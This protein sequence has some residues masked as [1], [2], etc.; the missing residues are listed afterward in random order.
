MAN[1]AT[2]AALSGPPYP[3]AV[4]PP[5]FPSRPD[6]FDEVEWG[7]LPSAK[8]ARLA[9]KLWSLQ[10]G[11]LANDI[12]TESEDH[13]Y[14]I[15]DTPS[16]I[17]H[18]SYSCLA[19]NVYEHLMQKPGLSLADDEWNED[20]QMRLAKDGANHILE[21]WSYKDIFGVDPEVELDPQK[22]ILG[23]HKVMSRHW[24]ISRTTDELRK[25]NV[26]V[27]K[28]AKVAG[29]RDLL[30]KDE[31]EK[32][33]KKAEDMVLGLLPREDQ[34]KWGIPRKNDFM[35]DISGRTSFRPLDMYTWAI[36]LS[37]YNPTYWV[38]R[39]Y[40]YYQMGYFDLA[41]GDVHRAQ[42][43][44]ETITNNKD[45]NKQPGLNIRIWNAVEQHLLEIPA[46]DENLSPE[47]ELMR[48]S[49]GI[50]YFIPTVRKALHHIMSL[51]LLALQCWKD[52]DAMD[53]YLPSRMQ[54]SA[55]DKDA[56]TD[57]SRSLE[58]FVSHSRSSRRNHH[59][60]AY[61][62]YEK[63]AGAAPGRT[64]PY[65]A[66]DV[67]RTKGIFL[68]KIDEDI[69]Q[70]SQEESSKL[71]IDKVG[72]TPVLSVFAKEKIKAGEV[73]YVDEPSARGHLLLNHTRGNP[74]TRCEN[75][76]AVI[77]NHDRKF[78][79]M[80]SEQNPRAIRNHEKRFLC[81]CVFAKDSHDEVYFCVPQYQEKLDIQGR[82]A[83]GPE[84]VSEETR[85]KRVKRRKISK[86]VEATQ[87][88][89][90]PSC[91]EIAREL[92]H[93]RTCG[94]DWTWLHDAMRPNWDRRL[95]SHRDTHDVPRSKY[96]RYSHANE[97]HCTVLSLLLREIFDITL[98]RREKEDKPNLLAHEIEEMMPLM[99]PEDLS[100]QQ[101][102]FTLAANIKVP[103]DILLCLGVDIF[104]DLTFDTW[105][106]QTVL[107]KLL[108]NAVPWDGHRRGINDYVDHNSME[109]NAPV[110]Y[111]WEKKDYKPEKFDP[112]I[113][114][115]YLF[116]GLSMFNHAC[117][118]HH[119]TTWEWDKKI[120]NRVMVRATQS[121]EKNEE[122]VL[123]Y[124]NRQF[125]KDS[126]NR[127]LG[128]PCLC[129]L[130]NPKK[131]EEG[132]PPRQSSRSLKNS[133]TFVESE[134]SESEQETP[135]PDESE[136][137]YSS[138]PT[139]PPDVA[140]PPS[141]PRRGARIKIA[142]GKGQWKYTRKA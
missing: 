21:G 129:T 38:S 59:A 137:S 2:A 3:G 97:T 36:L 68:E 101:F 51:S 48:Q 32:R 18:K 105:V 37:P 133:P 100:E 47:A 76:K 34:S 99:G 7:P 131:P 15:A 104:R 8:D 96:E 84:T 12:N 14:P 132:L 27:P 61:F 40:L 72:P 116:P 118:N 108:I 5:D 112:T 91:V 49:N 130:C 85:N 78:Y 89:E 41:L 127:V 128:G 11:V 102:P 87:R 64:Y 66:R 69:L 71:E 17:A 45:K 54:M 31:I 33:Q 88:K 135:S 23:G 109:P 86:D 16:V 82:G 28:N 63:Y 114:D 142:T 123:L 4:D 62:L 57:R 46:K 74:E 136:E 42:L 67:D 79:K 122:I 58:S 55:R 44:C 60:E 119:N 81:P 103:F 94:M 117:D 30:V 98:L 13:P 90:R 56:F 35:L 83:H 139:V 111:T 52:Y 43:L 80:L 141:P 70:G 39:A 10:D 93:Y 92:Y 19:H 73:I 24:T 6:L 138:T 53:E 134:S 126:A 9:Y 140:A 110:V 113:R 106:I 25:R 20:A 22:I 121:I 120:P 95:K 75:C 125:S 29:L 115:V 107:G 77:P 124:R 65:S 26:A 1:Q 50:N